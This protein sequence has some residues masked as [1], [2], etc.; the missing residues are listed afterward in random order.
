MSYFAGN[1]FQTKD[2]DRSRFLNVLVSK[3]DGKGRR[4]THRMKAVA[5]NKA[6]RPPSGS[7]MIHT[8]VARSKNIL[9]R[10]ASSP[11]QREQEKLKPVKEPTLRSQRNKYTTLAGTSTNE[12]ASFKQQPPPSITNRKNW[13]D[14]EPSKVQKHINQVPSIKPLVSAANNHK[15]SSFASRQVSS[16][17]GARDQKSMRTAQASNTTKIKSNRNNIDAQRQQYDSPPEIDSTI[18]YPV[19]SSVKHKYHGKGRVESPPSSD[20]EF[21]EKMLV[22]VRF[23]DDA[24]YWDLPMD[25]LMHTYE[26]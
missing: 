18:F 4:N 21:A 20:E 5:D 7:R 6:R 8:E 15:Q 9:P 13:D 22:R 14:W 12:F 25:S 26:S 23:E 2:T 17:S 10:S 24:D 19:G 16:T 3:G 11:L 1:S